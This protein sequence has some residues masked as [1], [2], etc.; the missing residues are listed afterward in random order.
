MNLALKLRVR[1]TQGMPVS[2]TIGGVSTNIP[3]EAAPVILRGLQIG[4]FCI[5]QVVGLQSDLDVFKSL[6]WDDTPSIILGLDAL[7]YTKIT[8]DQQA[9]TFEISTGSSYSHDCS[10]ERV[11]RSEY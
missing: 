7:Q 1:R 4:G 6:G 3:Q 8:V 5:R 11:Q 10:S 2:I 9:G